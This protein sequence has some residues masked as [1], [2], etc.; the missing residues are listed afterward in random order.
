MIYDNNVNSN[1]YISPET[2]IQIRSEA[3]KNSFNADEF[4]KRKAF[5]N[6]QNGQ[7]D[8]ANARFRFLDISKF[9]EKLEIGRAHV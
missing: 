8:H 5:E 1:E 2:H 9:T 7:E 4:L 3:S 6:L